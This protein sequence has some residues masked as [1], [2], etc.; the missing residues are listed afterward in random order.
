MRPVAKGRPGTT[1]IPIGWSAA[2]RPVVEGTQTAACTFRQPGGTRGPFNQTTG[3][4]EITP[5]PAHYTGQCRVQMMPALEQDPV[6]GDEQVPT[7]TYLVT[8][9]WDAAPDLAVDDLFTV[10]DAGPN[11]D[12]TLAGRDMR[13]RSFARGSLTWERDIY[14][15]D[16]LS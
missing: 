5:N 11:G 2:H 16:N 6:T 15:T 13:V 12:P 7:T 8:I 1:V 3:E 9:G 14:V 10:S 4:Y